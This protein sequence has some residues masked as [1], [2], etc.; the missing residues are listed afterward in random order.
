MPLYFITKQMTA[1]L[2]VDCKDEEEAR[3]WEMSIRATLEDEDG[4]PIPP[5]AIDDFEADYY[6][7]EVIV[8]LLEEN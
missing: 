5:N 2:T 7:S 1:Y 3:A 6:P 4:K 8:E